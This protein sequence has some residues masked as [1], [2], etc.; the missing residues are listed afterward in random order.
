MAFGVI[1]AGDRFSHRRGR[2]TCSQ[3][4][5]VGGDYSSESR[6]LQLLVTFQITD[7]ALARAGLVS[8]RGFVLH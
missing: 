6:H 1:L 5:W 3:G 4:P 2:R 8:R 7:L